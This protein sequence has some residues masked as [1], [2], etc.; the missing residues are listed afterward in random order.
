[1]A[2]EAHRRSG[3]C[4]VSSDFPRAASPSSH[5]SAGPTASTDATA[6]V[7]A[8][9]GFLGVGALVGVSKA[10][11]ASRRRRRAE[12]AGDRSQSP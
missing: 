10:N 4:P 6:G 12:A 9:V 8:F 5:S 7:S 1:M 11:S 2:M 3:M